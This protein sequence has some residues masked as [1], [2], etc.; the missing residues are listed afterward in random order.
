MLLSFIKSTERRQTFPGTSSETAGNLQDPAVWGERG[1]RD[2]FAKPALRCKIPVKGAPQ[3]P[4]GPFSQHCEIRGR[5]FFYDNFGFAFASFYC[6]GSLGPDYCR[7]ALTAIDFATPV[8]A[9]CS[10][11]LPPRNFPLRGSGSPLLGQAC[12]S[13]HGRTTK[14]RMTNSIRRAKCP[15]SK[16][17]T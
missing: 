16:A 1:Y 3:E 15:K 13:T 5:K 10:S 2:F 14:F 4:R 9:Y 7:I 17:S 6:S 11:F 8:A 12:R